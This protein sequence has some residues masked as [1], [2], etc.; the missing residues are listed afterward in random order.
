MLLGRWAHKFENLMDIPFI[1][2]FEEPI[3]NSV[4]SVFSGL[5]SHVESLDVFKKYRSVHFEM[6]ISQ[7]SNVKI[8]GMQTPMSLKSLYY[9]ANVS[10]DIRRRIYSPEWEGIDGAELESE[11][12]SSRSSSDNAISY[13]PASRP[14]QQR[15]A[16]KKINGLKA[17]EKG[18]QY[19]AK[20]NRVVIL[21]G[22]G[23]GKTTFIKF[24]ALAYS[25]KDIFKK[26]SL[27]Q[28]YFPIYIQLPLLA[29]ES[30]SVIDYISSHLVARTDQYASLFYSRLIE[31]G[32]CTILMDSLDEVPADLKKS[33][34]NNLKEFSKI[35]PKARIVIS[36][37]TADYDQVF[38]DF[39][40]V[41]LTRLSKEA[42]KSI[43]MAWFGKHSDRAEKLLAL[44]ENDDAVASLTET[45]L[46]LS[47]LCIQFKND[48]ALP[49]RKAELYRRCVDALLRDWDTTR[50]FRRDTAYSQLSDD[51]KEKIF[52]A[53]AGG[54][55]SEYISYEFHESFLL[56]TISDE[57]ARFSLDPNDARGILVEIESHHGII[58]K[59]SAETYEF[60]HG[61]MQEYF[62]ARYFVAKRMEM[63]VLKKYYDNEAWHDV[64]LFMSSMMDDSADVLNFLVEKSSMEKFQN[65]PAFGRRL[66]H[67]LLLYR[68]MAMGVNINPALRSSICKHLVDS[69]VNM[70]RQ[71]N[72]DGV[73]PYAARRPN[74]V[75]QANFHY[76]KARNSLDKVLQPYRS[77]MNEMVLSP[78]REY[79]DK[80]IDI[81]RKIETGSGKDR[82]KNLGLATCLLA[83]ISDADPK[84]FL[85]K[86]FEYSEILLHVKADTVRQ[87]I[88]ESI[89]THRGMHPDLF[90][91]ELPLF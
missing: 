16:G 8:L 60:S 26:T 53:V 4:M 81:V 36:C 87:V 47:L 76:R 65:Y 2:W 35:Y 1:D 46:L 37:R 25:D 66:A 42:V 24:I 58:E 83:P 48:L 38:E 14:V 70:L 15:G 30:C 22:P 18:D 84:F 3:K 12:S 43:V 85:E 61:T 44:L 21:G 31:T 52:D 57:I 75:R 89:N 34:I 6:L 28:S 23:A 45:P 77:L 56:S 54:T 91:G 82:F 19:I 41:E 68:C 9:P 7:V 29:K 5:N 62:A 79:S 67:L 11:S 73:L 78:I 40:E 39:S 20:N 86:M 51:R 13:R 27:D 71:I 63:A 69:Q 90:K 49:K 64:I 33:L 80:V 55:C 59:C 72:A 88:V 17:C 50:G 10:T 74:G 32:M